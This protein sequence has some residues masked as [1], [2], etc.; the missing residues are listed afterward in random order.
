MIEEWND[1]R[2]RTE[3]EVKEEAGRRH[4]LFKIH[5]ICGDDCFTARRDVFDAGVNVG[6]MVETRF[7]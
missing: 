2:A 1:S 4:S 5:R 7:R 6:E 3:A